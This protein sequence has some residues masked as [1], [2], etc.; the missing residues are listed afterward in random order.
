VGRRRES[1]FVVIVGPTAAGKSALALHVARARGGEVISADSMQVYRHFDIGTGKLPLEQRAG[2]PHHLIDVVEPNESFSAAEFVGLAD[3]AIAQIRA[4]GRLP[5]VVGGT[6]LYVRALLC[7]LFEAPP[8]DPAVRAAHQALAAERGVAW[9]HDELVRVDPTAASRIDTNDFVRISR[10]LEV[11]QQTGTPISELHRAHAFAQRRH[12]A[13]LVG[14]R[15]A[16]ERL[17]PAIDDR[18][19]QML[20]AGWLDE[21]RELCA[22]GYGQTHPM[23]ALGYRQLAAYLRG[24]LSWDQAVWQTRRDTWRFARRQRNW[25][26]H[27]KDIRWLDRASDWDRALTELE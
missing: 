26:G 25:F 9:M 1:P 19:D 15:V 14:L 21:V 13:T 12:S 3:R 22:R 23:G 2:V 17:R 5:I 27:E 4:R 8:A 6:G 18:I 20:A 24:E 11:Y 10:A 7:G 16:P